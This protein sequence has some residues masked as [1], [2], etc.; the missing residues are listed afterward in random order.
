VQ[1]IAHYLRFPPEIILKKGTG[2]MCSFTVLTDVEIEEIIDPEFNGLYVDFDE[3]EVILEGNFNSQ[4]VV[5]VETS[6]SREYNEWNKA[7]LRLSGNIIIEYT[8]EYDEERDG[9]E[10]KNEIISV[11]NVNIDKYEPLYKSQD[12]LELACISCGIRP[13]DY[14]TDKNEPVCEECLTNFEVCTGCGKLFEIGTLPG[15]KCL[16]C[17][18]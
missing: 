2:I 18:D 11:S 16:D 7:E 17:D 6:L 3:D 4:L 12:F 13:G 8:L 10:R 15:S 14:R 9:I 5:E 1:K